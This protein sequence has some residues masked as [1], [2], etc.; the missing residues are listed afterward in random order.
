MIVRAVR[1][2]ADRPEDRAG[3]TKMIAI[4]YMNA[5]FIQNRQ[6]RDERIMPWTRQVYL[7]FK[8]ITIIKNNCP[9]IIN[10]SNVNVFHLLAYIFVHEWVCLCVHKPCRIM[11][12]QT[13]RTESQHGR[14]EKS[15]RNHGI[16]KWTDK[17]PTDSCRGVGKTGRAE[18]A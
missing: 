11:R 6:K 18:L 17:T 1:N 2:T 9:E 12:S 14:E 15:V 4:I 13:A 3:F 8:K 5:L 16:T 7:L 10:H